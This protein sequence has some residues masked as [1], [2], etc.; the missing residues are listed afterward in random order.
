[1]IRI[2]SDIHGNYQILEHILNYCNEKDEIY[3]LGDAIDR[4]PDGY[5]C[6]EKLIEDKRV[7]YIRGNHEQMLIDAWKEYNSS[8]TDYDDIMLYVSN[9]GRSTWEDIIKLGPKA[10]EFINK[11]KIKMIDY[12]I[13]EVNN[14]I[15][16]LTHSGIDPIDIVGISEEDKK[17]EEFRNKIIWNR[18]HFLHNCYDESLV[19]NVY[20]IHGHTPIEYLSRKRRE[21][22]C[23]LRPFIYD[24]GYKVDIDMGT[25]STGVSALLTIDA[26]NDII[27]YAMFN[28]NGLYEEA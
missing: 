5:K 14:A 27:H 12:K 26:A 7:T 8:E 19:N 11:L 21:E 28:E 16:V 24:S 2:F 10:K 17:T 1:M 15:F 6:M 3:F 13:L 18:E 23:Q 25:F 9:G 22:L 20:I 4:G